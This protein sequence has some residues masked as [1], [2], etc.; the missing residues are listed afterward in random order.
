[1]CLY[2]LKRSF[3]GFGG[4]Y[5]A[6]GPAWGCRKVAVAFGVGKE[7]VVEGARRGLIGI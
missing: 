1:V 7:K 6:V 5:G 4:A 3:I 2:G